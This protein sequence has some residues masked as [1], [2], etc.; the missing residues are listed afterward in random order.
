MDWLTLNPTSGNTAS[1][2]STQVTATIDRSKIDGIVSTSV[3]VS[4]G[5][6]SSTIVF[7]A[8]TGGSGAAVMQLSENT[9]NFGDTET[10][11][12]FQ[13]KNVGT[14]G[15]L[16]DWS[17]S[18]LDVD[19][20]T[21]NPMSGSTNAG[22]GTIVTAV[23]DRTKINDNVSTNVTVNGGGNSA[24]LSVMA[25]YVDNSVVIG[26]GLFCFFNFDGDEI[27]DYNGNY[28]GINSG[29]EVSTDTPSGEGKS[30]QFNGQSSS[31]LVQGSIV[32]SGKNYTINIWF[33]TGKG[34]HALIGSDNH[35][36]GN[37]CSAL[38]ITANNNVRYYPNSSAYN[39]QTGEVISPYLDNKWHMLTLTYNG[40]IG[41]V[42]VDGTVLEA[43]SSDRLEWGSSVTT[44]LFGADITNYTLGYYTGKL[45]NFRSYNRALS[46]SEIQTLF[47][48]KQ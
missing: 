23:I 48:A 45:D 21:F 7:T 37:R 44:T 8:S 25:S 46:A 31:V 16:L 36:G 2:S 32:P 11:K 30:L 9:L 35:S 12:T 14:A 1:G 3:T 24:N 26:D 13:V 41:I 38:Y 34:D 4:G 43:H 20:L 29:A 15:T 42:Y 6:T 19:W 5:G 10:T 17:I 33:K 27:V 40:T 47:N 39:W 18:A 22:S 28:T